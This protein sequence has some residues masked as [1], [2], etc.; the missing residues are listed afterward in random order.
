MFIPF[1]YPNGNCNDAIVSLVEAAGY[2]MAVTT[3]KGWNDSKSNRFRLNRYGV[4]ED[5]SS[6]IPMF[7][8]SILNLI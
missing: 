7:A 4:H 1:C 3:Q 2:D 6:T 8:G 5:I